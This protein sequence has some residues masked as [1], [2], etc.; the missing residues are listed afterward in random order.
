[1]IITLT[2]NPSLDRTVTLGSALTPG[3][4]HRIDSD[5]TQPGGKGVNVAFGVMA[6]GVP[7]LA[8]LPANSSDR[9]VALLKEEG[10]AFQS[11]PVR[12]RVRTN[13]TILGDG[14]TTKINEAGERLSTRE[15]E[16]VDDALINAVQ[17]GDTVML[18]G[19][20][21]PGFPVDEYSRLI[22]KLRPLG[23]WVGVDTSDASL[24][25]LAENFADAAPDFLKPNGLEL[26]QLT[27]RDGVEIE[28]FAERGDLEPARDAALA[29]RSQGVGEVL[30][31]L[32]GAGAILATEEGVWFSPSPRVDVVST[33]GAGDSAT[34]GYLIAREEGLPPAECL[35]LAVAYG[36][37]AVSLPGTTIPLPSQVLPNTAAVR[38]I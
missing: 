17:A 27:G 14:E 22:R 28:R 32:G 20:L 5:A 24:V 38:R 29:L 26:G 36:S 8:L 11:I 25:A 12:G 3:A 33:V 19:S 4:V 16:A 18:S 9:L 7:V 1:M 2:A 23:V 30:V 31:T 35:A 34:A 15:V 6:A 10:L 37:T 13:L 21:A